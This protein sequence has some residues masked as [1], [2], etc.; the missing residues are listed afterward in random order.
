MALTPDQYTSLK[1]AILAEPALATAVQNADDIAIAEFFNQP[2]GT[3]Q[4]WRNDFTPAQM[5][6]AMLQ[7]AAELDG[8][9]VGRRDSLFWLTAES[10]DAG[11]PAVRQ[12]FIDFTGG[13]SPATNTRSALNAA[14]KRPI[15][16]FEKI[17]ATGP[18][19]GA[20]VLVVVGPLHYSDAGTALRG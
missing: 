15:T 20:Y 9:T 5:R 8:L 16:K 19:S 10:V 4:C 17:F 1:T 7:G 12:A 18:V 3:D 14:A 13:S 2:S 11:N 6:A